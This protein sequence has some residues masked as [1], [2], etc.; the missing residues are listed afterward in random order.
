MACLMLHSPGSR[1]SLG[2]TLL[3][4][5]TPLLELVQVASRKSTG[6]G[7]VTIVTCLTLKYRSLENMPSAKLP[8][9]H[10]LEVRAK[11][12]EH[13]ETIAPLVLGHI[14][15]RSSA[16]SKFS[17]VKEYVQYTKMYKQGTWVT[18]IELLVLSHLLDH[19]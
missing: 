1:L 16:M 5:K 14:R 17:S 15:G 18:E 7:A 4:L 19:K 11:T 6:L 9:L 13:M 10:L 3:L 12:L 2:C 8:V